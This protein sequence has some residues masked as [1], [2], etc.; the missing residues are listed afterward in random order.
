MTPVVGS[1]GTDDNEQPV[2]VNNVGQISS[3]IGDCGGSNDIADGTI[4]ATSTGGNSV[5]INVDGP[6][7]LTTTGNTILG[8][9]G[10]D[11][12][13]VNATSTFNAGAGGAEG[14]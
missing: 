1:H 2:C 13:T 9:G 11:T 10:A 14:R 4:T 6:G 7:S 12:L 3:Q 8:N 5:K